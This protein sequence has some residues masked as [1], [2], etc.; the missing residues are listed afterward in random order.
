MA[1][2]QEK[3]RRVAA[4][5]F[6]PRVQHVG[7]LEREAGPVYYTLLTCLPGDDFVNVYAEITVVQQRQL[8][9]D[10][11][12]FLDRLYDISGTHYDIGLYIPAISEFTGTWRAG[13]Q[14]YWELLKQGVEGLDLKPESVRVFES[15]F[16]FLETSVD[17]LDYQTGPRLLHNDFHPK[18]ILLDR[19]RFSGV[20]DWECSQYG[21][22]DLELCHLVHW[23]F[24]LPRPDIDFRPFL[25]A[26][27]Q[28]AP[29]CAQVPDLAKRLTIYQVEHE[30]QQIIWH[31]RKGEAMRVP[32]LVRWVDGGVE[33]LLSSL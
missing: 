23:C 32:R 21:E 3:F 8:G 29:K 5:P 9:K 20:I 14:E 17:A 7:V 12:A 16:R 6:V 24:D 10:V 25:G 2:E 31:G 33:D 18:N 19:G 11:A 27:L 1:G 28:A 30:I 13:Q 15:A 4:L 22:A 26:L